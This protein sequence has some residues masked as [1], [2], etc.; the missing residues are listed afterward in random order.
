MAVLR[1]LVLGAEPAAWHALGFDVA[2][3]GSARLDGV[4]L[5]LEGGSGGVRAWAV[6]GVRPGIADGLE[7]RAAKDDRTAGAGTHPNGA[8]A[9]DHVVAFTP[10][11]DRTRAALEA[12]GLEPRGERD[13]G[14]GVRQAFWVLGTALLELAGPVGEE[15]PAR[16]WG[17]V[18]VVEDLDRAVE[19]GAGA[20]GPPK[21]A[22]QP[23]RQIATVREDA[24]LGLP[25][26]YMTPRAR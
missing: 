26:A 18:V 17:L 13:A 21:P 6:E 20:V 2:G 1:E 14:S 7:F 8:C 23:G 19:L 4:T 15:G 9:L 3:D 16:F 22:V 10:D 11:L 12:L 5:R 24:G 25:V